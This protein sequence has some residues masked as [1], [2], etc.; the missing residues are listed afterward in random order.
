MSALGGALIGLSASLLMLSHGRIAG[1]SG[2]VGGL[3]E[4]RS[5]DRDWRL[6]FVLGLVAGGVALLFAYPTAFAVDIHRNSVVVVAAGLLV[7]F[8]ARLGSGCTSG[9]GV[10]GISRFSRRSLVATATFMTTGAITT[11]VYSLVAGGA[12]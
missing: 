11:L 9:H 6:A 8:G 12:S 1:I 2:I 4:T 10:C 3:L 7:G 5:K